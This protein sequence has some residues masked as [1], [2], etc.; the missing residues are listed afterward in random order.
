M[1]IGD[2]RVIFKP[3]KEVTTEEPGGTGEHDNLGLFPGCG[4][5]FN[6]SWYYHKRHSR[7]AFPINGFDTDA[8]FDLAGHLAKGAAIHEL[9]DRHDDTELFADASL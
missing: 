1:N 4:V 7:L 5:G 6:G 3:L 9:E 2:V 8:L